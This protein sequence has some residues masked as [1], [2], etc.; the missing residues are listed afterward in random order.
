VK[1]SLARV[2]R[3]NGNVEQFCFEEKIKHLKIRGENLKFTKPLC[4]RGEIENIG[5]GIFQASG[6]I[7]STVEDH[8]YRCLRPIEINIDRSFNIKFSDTAVR[9]EDENEDIIQINSDEIEFTPYVLNEI[10]LNWPGQVLC[11]SECKGLC[12]H[13]GADLNKTTCDCKDDQIDPR[14]S[15]LKQFT[16]ED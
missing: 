7:S 3:F 14:L 9:E 15:I 4:V 10:I 8:C 6:F 2:K 5:K 13:C 11:S 12:P 16:N 1:I